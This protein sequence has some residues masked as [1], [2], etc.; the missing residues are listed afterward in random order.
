[1]TTLIHSTASRWCHHR[2]LSI[3]ALRRPK[4]YGGWPKSLPSK[5]GPWPLGRG[6]AEASA[7]RAFIPIRDTLLFPINPFTCGIFQT[8]PLPASLPS[9]V[10]P[11]QALTER[12]A[13]V[14]FKMSDYLKKK[15]K[16]KTISVLTWNILRLYSIEYRLKRICNSMCYCVANILVLILVRVTFEYIFC[17]PLSSVYL[18]SLHLFLHYFG[19]HCSSLRLTQISSHTALAT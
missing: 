4:L 15:K 9:F 16:H 5:W 6:T 12:V 19:I 17:I 7:S 10:E 3:V 18:V 1:M 8:D 11:V 14:N 13:G 2:Q